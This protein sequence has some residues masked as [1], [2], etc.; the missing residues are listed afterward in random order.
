MLAVPVMP[1]NSCFSLESPPS[2][3]PPLRL[4]SHAPVL[5][6]TGPCS[7]RHA[8]CCAARLATLR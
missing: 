1:L 6:S 7:N 5:I 2:G 4:K 8:A 3:V